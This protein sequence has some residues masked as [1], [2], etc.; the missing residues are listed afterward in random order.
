MLNIKYLNNVL[1]KRKHS[2]VCVS[3]SNPVRSAF[4]SALHPALILSHE[5]I[6]FGEVLGEVLDFDPFSSQVQQLKA[7]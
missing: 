2:E 1:N 6:K 3:N 7:S 4:L 5:E